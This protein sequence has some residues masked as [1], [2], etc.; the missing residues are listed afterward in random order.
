VKTEVFVPYAGNADIHLLGLT[1]DAWDTRK[2][3]PVAILVKNP[4]NETICRVAAETVA[5]GDYILAE[6]GTK[7]GDCIGVKKCRKGQGIRVE[8]VSPRIQ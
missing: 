1:M 4:G 5:R 7:P 6:L 8:A 3:E 2:Y